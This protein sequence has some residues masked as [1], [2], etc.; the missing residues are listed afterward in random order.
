MVQAGRLHRYTYADYVAL[1]ESSTTKHEYFQGAI[2]AMA[3]GSEDHPA[4]SAEMLR[5][6][7]NALGDRPCRAHTSDLRIYIEASG[8]AT[9]PDGAVICGKLE[10]HAA[11]PRATAL[12]RERRL[13]LHYRAES[14]AWETRVAI[15]G[16]KLASSSL[17]VEL[18]TDDIYRASSI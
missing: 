10:Q 13:T 8:M 11:S 7:G 3:G 5:V 1:E 15:A 6:L 16:G 4:L 17:P 12:N 18:V 14:G 2:Y 9:F